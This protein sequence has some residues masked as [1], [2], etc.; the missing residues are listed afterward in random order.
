ME[1]DGELDEETKALGAELESLLQGDLESTRTA[2]PMV[3]W[4]FLPSAMCFEARYYHDDL[5][6]FTFLGVNQNC[7]PHGVTT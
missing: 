3:S 6:P 2:S 5:G 1:Y 4:Q 7:L